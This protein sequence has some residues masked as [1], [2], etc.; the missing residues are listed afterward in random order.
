MTINFHA[1]APII[2]AT[3]FFS[4]AIIQM[5]SVCIQINLKIVEI[6]NGKSTLNHLVYF[7]AR[8]ELIFTS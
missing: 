6:N 5:D 8:G 7:F 4:W 2:L 1:L 3:K